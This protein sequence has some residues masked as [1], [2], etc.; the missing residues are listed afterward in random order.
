MDKNA[1]AFF[2]F[3]GTLVTKDSLFDIA[4]F[5]FGSLRF[6]KGIL[7]FSPFLF[8]HM[9]GLISKKN[10]KEIYLKIFFGE[11]NY[12][13]FQ[14][15]C[16]SYSKNRIPHILDKWTFERLLFHRKNNHRIYI[17]TASPACWIEPWAIT[18]G[19]DG[20]IS[21]ELIINDNYMSRVILGINCSGEQKVH[22]IMAEFPNIESKKIFAYGN[23]KDDLPM[24]SIADE[25]YLN[26]KLVNV[27]K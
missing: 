24:L 9:T 16:E 11:M 17:V 26:R 12:N 7:F 18:N 20:V 4:L 1:I 3:D 5:Y 14:N 25:A 23:S 21:T 8:L 15:I 22:R 19:I 2:D 27:K 10:I 6:I 13:S